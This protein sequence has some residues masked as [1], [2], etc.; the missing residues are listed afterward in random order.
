MNDMMKIVKAVEESGLLKKKV[1]VKQLKMKQKNE[2]N[3][4]SYYYVH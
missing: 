3:D 1:L 2:K 4:F